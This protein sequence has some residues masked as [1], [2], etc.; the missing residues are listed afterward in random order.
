MTNQELQQ[1]Y[2]AVRQVWEQILD[3]YREAFRKVS[4][5]FRPLVEWAQTPEGQAALAEVGRR[6]SL[7]TC[8]CLC[9]VTHA[10]RMVNEDGQGLCVGEATTRGVFP[11]P[12]GW[13]PVAMCGPCA[14][15]VHP[16]G[17]L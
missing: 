17:V 13:Q 8:R 16:G 15:E 6:F 2:E 12:W 4:E 14:G 7:P 3:R 1:Q 5:A 11:A 9:Q 10:H